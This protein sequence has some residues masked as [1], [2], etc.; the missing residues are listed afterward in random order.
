[1][2][3]K[4]AGVFLGLI[5]LL[6]ACASDGTK[7]QMAGGPK[8]PTASK[9]N[10]PLSAVLL[11][12]AMSNHFGAGISDDDRAEA[13]K[14]EQRAFVA[15]IGQQVTWNNASNGHKGTIIAL[16]DGYV[17]NGSYCR[18]FLQTIQIEGPSQQSYGKACQ[19]PD[20]SWKVVQ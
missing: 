14:A 3:R 10:G 5:L 16:R 7:D 20:G 6:T 11:D 18:E 15:P 17:A 2:I 13:M 8:A 9:Q 4:N 19:L 12:G 1:M